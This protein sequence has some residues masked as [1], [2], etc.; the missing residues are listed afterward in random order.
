MGV[1]FTR[2]IRRNLL[3]PICKA[4]SPGSVRRPSQLSSI[5]VNDQSFRRRKGE[6]TVECT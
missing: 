1:H 5:D 6:R 4:F 2:L 3:G